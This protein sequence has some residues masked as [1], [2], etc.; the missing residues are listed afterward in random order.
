MHMPHHQASFLPLQ[1]KEAQASLE[2]SSSRGVF[3]SREN[4][5]KRREKREKQNLIK[6]IRLYLQK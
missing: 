5:G 2:L 6:N 4:K 1:R 3:G